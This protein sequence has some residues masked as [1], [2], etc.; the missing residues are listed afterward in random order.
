MEYYI[1]SQVSCIDRQIKELEARRDAILHGYCYIGYN[2]ST[3]TYL[4]PYNLDDK[5]TE[6]EKGTMCYQSARYIDPYNLDDKAT[7]EEKE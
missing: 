1:D 5:A 4:D 3:K 2:I 7:E 6:E